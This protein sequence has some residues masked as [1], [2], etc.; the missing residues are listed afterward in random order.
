MVPLQTKSAFSLLKSPMLPSALVE[1]AKAKGY[2]AVALTDDDVLYGLDNFYQAAQKA[3]IQPI[4]GLT[5]H[6]KGLVLQQTYPLILLVENQV[7]YQH[8]LAISSQLASQSDGQVT[9][10]QL[11]DLLAGLFVIVPSASEL[12]V[13]LQM[14]DQRQSER[15]LKELLTYIPKDHLFLGASTMMPGTNLSRLKQLATTFQTRLVALDPVEYANPDDQFAAQVMK[16]IGQGETFANVALARRQTPTAFLPAPA[17]WANQFSQYGLQ[18]AVAMT[19]WIAEHSQFIL[20]KTPNTLPSIE[21]PPEENA[22]TYLHDLAQAG[23]T[24]RLGAEQARQKVYQDRLQKELGIIN[25]LGFDDYFLIVWDVIRFAH[26]ADIRTGPGRGSAAGSLVAYALAIT[27]VDPLKYDL[28]F[29]RFLNPERAQMP[30]IDIDIPD[31]RRE[32]VLD[33]LHGK[34]GHER[35]A[36]IITFSTMSTRAV[37]RDVA[38]T[39][40]LNPSQIDQLAKTIPRQLNITLE[41][42]YEQSQ[43]FRNALLDL[44]VDG[45]LLLA[46]AKKLEG[47]PRNSSLH[48]AGVVLSADPIVEVIPVQE[49]DDGRLVTQLTKG[50]VERLGLLKMDFLAL[51]NLNILDTAL[52]QVKKTDPQFNIATI[53]LNDA[54]TLAL[55]Q[56]GQTNGIFQFESA[57][58][59]NMLRQ[60]RPDRFEDIVAANALFRPGPSQNIGH[61]IARKQGQEA[62]RDIDASV[63]D[64]L[65][66]TY[67]IIVYQEQVMRVAERF[68][69]FSLGAA[70][71]LRR[72][73]SKK[74]A[75]KLATIKADF[76]AGAQAQGHALAL[77]EQV[78][79]YIETFAQYGFNRSHSVAYSK[80][81]FQLAYL[82]AHFPVAFYKAVL[83]DAIMDHAKV[84]T[85]LAEARQAQVQLVGPNINQSFQ[86]Y[87]VNRQGQ[88]QMGLASIKGLRKDFRQ[89]LLDNRLAQ[90]PYP[91]LMTLIGRLPNK[92]RKVELLEPLVLTG[93]LDS[94]DANRKQL[95]ASLQS[96]I[97]AVGLAGESMSLFEAVVPKTRQVKPYSQSEQLAFEEEYLGVY[98]SGHPLEPYQHLPHQAIANLV[99]GMAS[100][101]LL[102]F[103]DQVKVIRTKKGDQM[104][105]LEVTDLTG[106]LSVT[107]FARLYQQVA[108]QL[109]PH[110][111][112]SITGKVEQERRGKGLQIVAS[113]ITVPA[114]P[115]ES[116]KRWYLRLTPALVSAGQEKTLAKLLAANAGSIPVVLVYAGQE[117]S[118]LLPQTEWLDDSE[119]TKQALQDLL[120]AENVVLKA[121][122]GA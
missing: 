57:G 26:E 56:A 29:E 7:G 15:L 94:F 98:L 109:V 32:E 44:P 101:R 18:D 74:D 107:I 106:H 63:A 79:G 110:Q 116:A 13:L 83:N 51:S 85:Y 49:G 17:D 82:K 108:E 121:H 10:A 72:A 78:Y 81:A 105:F 1:D 88:L 21:L 100:V 3:H 89:A 16:K 96:Y 36:Q 62:P 14:D 80:L 8:L 71:L 117:R 22:Q 27:D 23:L 52:R 73:M 114:K 91:D 42:A 68:A 76:L 40:G 93:A 50:P 61:F 118:V 77:A 55:F 103:V 84:R 65:A 97:D 39:F 43:A 92:F 5:A 87:T 45:E 20:E 104:A 24:A 4:L 2:S 75:A 47:L 58:M 41:A 69:G 115:A 67:G 46:T 31:D 48:A 28:L 120:G 99:V 111:I 59:K 54:A 60:L 66:P 38:R 95:L 25:E 119:K 11:A 113:T 6:L 35:V 90:G 122:T 30:D 34:Y 102:V 12:A 33:Y 70:D 19:D 37:I 9:L 86:G 112:L 64:I 53:D